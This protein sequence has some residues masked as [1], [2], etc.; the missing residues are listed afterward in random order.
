MKDVR[1]AA[2]GS[3]EVSCHASTKGMEAAV[4]WKITCSKGVFE[5]GDELG[6]VEGPDRLPRLIEVDL[7][8]KGMVKAEEVDASFARALPRDDGTVGMAFALAQVDADSADGGLE[9]DVAVPSDGGRVKVS[10]A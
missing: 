2:A 6:L 1:E 7:V 5:E 10:L 8:A 4:G 3:D 9:D